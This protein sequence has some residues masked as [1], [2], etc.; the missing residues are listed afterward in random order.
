MAG[1]F[2]H[3]NNKELATQ[4]LK[5]LDRGTKDMTSSDSDEEKTGHPKPAQSEPLPGA[6]FNTKTGT[7][8]PRWKSW[9]KRE[10]F[11]RHGEVN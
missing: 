8:H 1:A 7:G 5:S 2:F 3:L 10:E 6:K 9:T 4:N 11:P